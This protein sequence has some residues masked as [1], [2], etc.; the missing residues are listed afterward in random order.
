MKT[1]K[2]H[3][4]DSNSAFDAWFR[5]P[6][7]F[8]A[9]ALDTAFSKIRKSQPGPV[10]DPFAGVATVGTRARLLGRD[11]VGIEA[12]PLIA[13]IARLKLNRPRHP[14]SLLRAA[15]RVAEAAIPE[16]S[17]GEAELV[18]RC[19]SPAILEELV[20]L[21]SAILE[22]QPPW[23]AY[24]ELA[25]LSLLR[26]HAS[27]KVGWPYQLPGKSRQPRLANPTDRFLRL[28]ER[29]ADDLSAANPTKAWVTCGDSR[30]AAAWQTAIRREP[31]AMI[32]SPPYLNN[33]DYADATRLE[34]YFSKRASSWAEMC[35]TVRSG[36]VVASTQ[37]SKRPD[38]ESALADLEDGAPHFHQRIY[39]LIE[40]LSTERRKRL[41][42]KHYDWMV[43]LYFRDLWQVLQNVKLCLPK[44]APVVWV[45]GDSAPYGI[46]LDTPGL[47]SQLG[48]E[49]GFKM[50]SQQI[51]RSRG[52]RWRT[53]GSRHQVDLCEKQLVWSAPGHD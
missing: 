50:R 23:D 13:R 52:K 31:T 30:K 9:E 1:G 48:E 37:Q 12:H 24:L 40:A 28:C 16:V 34:L 46:Y 2:K 19:F 17:E 18:T 45:I 49:L 10:L 44:G 35:E 8:S 53:N 27:V 14:R 26:D 41:S 42:G 43:S 36:M 11:F 33:F 7:G 20:G 38:A 32:S 5:Y 4:A 15:E 39:H 3:G 29:M 25:L 51:L 6:A 47:L 21:R 22:E